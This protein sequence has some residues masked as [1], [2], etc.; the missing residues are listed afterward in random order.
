MR[1]NFTIDGQSVD[2]YQIEISYP[3]QVYPV[4]EFLDITS[5]LLNV[6]A[7]KTFGVETFKH[8]YLWS[9][10]FEVEKKTHLNR[11]DSTSSSRNLLL[12]T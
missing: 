10:K 5:R 4:A 1:F 2:E 12:T 7:G 9:H 8:N 6:D 11:L 3:S